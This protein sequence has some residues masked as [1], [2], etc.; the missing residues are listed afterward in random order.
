[1]ARKPHEI[2]P[3]F[4]P[5]LGVFLN[6]LEEIRESSPLYR[7]GIKK[8]ANELAAELL[9][10][11]KDF[12]DP[13]RY[14]D[15]PDPKK[16]RTSQMLRLAKGFDSLNTLFEMWMDVCTL[17]REEQEKF[18][19]EYEALLEKYGLLELEKSKQ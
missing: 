6:R 11:D 2:E 9:K 8:A 3:Y 15:H 14:K 19:G 12:L 16:A 10:L 4:M 5:L 18:Y 13:E 7:K 1:M 17:P